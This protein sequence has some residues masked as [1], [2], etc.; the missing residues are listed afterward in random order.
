MISI[1][2][3]SDLGESFGAWSMGHDSEI[4]SVVSSANVACG[5]HA[6]DP[7]GILKTLRDADRFD[8][9]I[10]AHV[11]YRDLVGF[12]RRAMDISYDELYSDVIY[13]IGALQGLA[14]SI[15]RRVSYIKPHGALYN[16]IARDENQAMAVIDAIKAL[17][18]KLPLMALAGSPLVAWATDAGIRVIGE[19]FADRAYHHDGR[20]VSRRQ[21][22]AVLHQPQQVAE[23]MINWLKTGKI[24]SIEGEDVSVK[25]E[26]ICIHGDSPAAVAMAQSLKAMLV[27]AGITIQSFA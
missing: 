25:G 4:L 20:L 12:G 13:Q 23:R 22:G 16:T 11:G 19:V 7:A 18:V 9:T 2:L 21:E 10:G 26:S 27:E 3:N 1:D 6:G 15:G 14:N 5:F 24:V 17:D 8:V